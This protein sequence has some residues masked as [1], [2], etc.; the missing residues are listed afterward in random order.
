M[1]FNIRTIVLVLGITHLMQ[2]L[3]FVHQFR[4]NKQY[5]GI[6]WWL[7]WS[8][9]EII[10]FAFVLMRD[11]HSLLPVAIIGRNTAFVLGIAFL[12]IGIMRFF[13]KK[14][15]L[16]IIIPVLVIYFF[17]LLY[18]LFVID[19]IV[20]RSLIIN[21]VLAGFSFI[22]AYSLYKNKTITKN[23]TVNFN[24]IIFILHG[25]V[26]AFRFVMI[27]AG[28]RMLDMLTPTLFNIV[29]II[30]ALVVSLLWT[31]GLI[32]MVNQRLYLEA[33]ETKTHF[34]QIFS[35]SPDA[36]IITSLKDGLIVNCNEGYN[37]IT[38][39]SKEEIIGKTTSEI[40]IWKDLRDREEV[41][42]RVLQD[43]FCE[44]YE[45]LF[46]KKDGTVIM[47]LMSA[48][49][50]MLDGVKHIISISRDITERKNTE[51]KI[52]KAN[53]IYSFIS[54]INE[55]TIRSKSRNEL[56]NEA[57]RIAVDVGKFRMSWIGIVDE[58]TK[59]VI[60]E[61][62]AGYEDGYLSRIKKIRTSDEPE[63]RGPTGTSI[64][65]GKHITCE[66]IENDPNIKPWR[67]EALK[68]GY[69]SSIALPLK[70]FGKVIGAF[71][72]YSD[73]AFFFDKE[74]IALLVEVANN[75]S[76]AIEAMEIKEEL[77][78]SEEKFKNIF[79][80]AAVGKS[81][82]SPDGKIS[83]NKAYCDIMGYS[84]EELANI[85]FQDLTFPEDIEKDNEVVKSLLNGKK[86][87]ERWQKRYIHKSG[88][89]IWA[90]ISTVLQKDSSGKPMYFITTISDITERKKIEE[91]FNKASKHFQALI[92]KAS[93]GVV[94]LNAEGQFKYLSPNAKKMFGY[95]ESVETMGNPVEYTHL[96]DVPMVLEHL[97]KLF[98]DE[99]YVPKLEYRFLHKNG[100]WVWI[101][102]TF[103]NL[104]SDPNVE[105]IL[106][107][108][109]DITERKQAEEEIRKLNDE[110]ERRVIERTAQLEVAN[111]ELEAF[112]YSVSHDLRAPLRGIDGFSHALYEDYYDKLDDDARDFIRRI[113]TATQK[114]D[115]L[116]DSMLRLSR[117]SRLE[118]YF[119]EVNLS[120]L[121]K[122]A[123][124]ALQK[125]DITR[126]A[127]FHIQE[128]VFAMGD[129]KL[130]QIVMENLF[131]N[132]WKFTSRMEKTVIEFGTIQK[133]S[134][135]MY[136]IKDNGIG[137]DMKY[138]DKLFNAFQRLH[139]E[140][141][142]PGTGVGLTT[143]QRIIRRHGGEIYA[144][145]K[146]GSG[147]VFYFSIG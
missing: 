21:A 18:F 132:A 81:I 128:E 77:R 100:N 7:M 91:K 116:I 115:A 83:V 109:H 84:K 31:F 44:N 78:F 102:S 38:G 139:P 130:L 37:K 104:L 4:V 60:P 32:I 85:K 40:N 138:T 64:K 1:E 119:E 72:L 90:D 10:G 87:S 68:R 103:S 76:Y 127:G 134:K 53:R 113:R 9:S 71:T 13:G 129:A 147:A 143:V 106:I 107:N 112:S 55:S 136:Y 79:E 3:V 70:L 144:E 26:F 121:A 19:D 51:A 124:E 5:K 114:M 120:L 94:L 110:L 137:F 41:V 62:I 47:G 95:T 25:S 65:E 66:D 145:S 146:P 126:A 75:I 133:N 105:S 33:V 108:F 88:R 141:D 49:V 2:V 74:E 39:Y 43:G 45:A 50:I 63:G 101:E 6:G 12:Y 117:V 24:T 69:R 15:N 8:V 28:E 34:E 111:K 54:R 36:V 125:S 48:K 27:L 123:A 35:T 57:V 16:R 61:Y 42:K 20:I 58:K 96:D 86:N 29:P 14:E 97:G 99:T 73:T 30:D 46:Q 11:I 23:T 142:F 89:I 82:T 93:D 80:Q 59:T 98:A 122:A 135:L 118:M 22:T 17:G 140:K 52:L 67:D 131:N 92:E 56:F